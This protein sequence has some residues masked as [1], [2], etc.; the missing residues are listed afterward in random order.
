MKYTPEQIKEISHRE[1]TEIADFIT[2]LLNH[3]DKL[4]RHI[5]KL[6]TRMHSLER[7]VGLTSKNSSKPPSSDGLRKPKS[8]RTNG[9]KKGAPKNHDGHTLRMVE[10]PD[11]IE[12]HILHSCA[13]CDRSL[14]G[15][16][17]TA[18]CR[19]QVFDLPLPQ[20]IVTEH[21]LEKKCCPNCGTK[22][23][24]HAPK[25]VNA[26]VQYGES[27]TAWCA[28][29]HTYHHLP[30]E[31]IGQLFLDMTGQRPSDATLLR[32]LASVSAEIEPFIPY[33]REELENSVTLHA[34]ETGMR[35]QGKT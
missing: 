5:E 23:Q 21:R 9:G 16:P 24:A 19:R 2:G 30:L 32:G 22:Q 20:L 18:Y 13:N 7:Q 17:V 35:V 34:D 26:P 15:V 33:I 11:A 3:I 4:E 10:T 25:Q 27:W 28:Y 29:L 1:P 31:R 12:T 6:E 14:Q 8:L